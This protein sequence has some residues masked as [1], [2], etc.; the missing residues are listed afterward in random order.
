MV[1]D[2]KDSLSGASRDDI[3]MSS[4]D[5]ASLHL[6]DG[7]PI[8]LESEAGSFRG[9]I[10]ESPILPGN[11]QVHWPEGMRLVGRQGSDPDSGIPDYNVVVSVSVPG[12]KEPDAV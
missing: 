1:W 11:L 12:E 3:L 7:D 4:E 10:K 2:W 8:V 6:E 9:M 5:V